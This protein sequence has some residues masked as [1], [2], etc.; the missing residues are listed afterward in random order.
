MKFKSGLNSALI[1]AALLLGPVSSALSA[2][3]FTPPT[4]PPEVLVPIFLTFGGAGTTQALAWSWGAARVENPDNP[5]NRFTV[6]F[7]DV[8]VTRWIDEQSPVFPEK[9]ALGEVV[10]V[11]TLATGDLTL[12]MKTVQ[13]TS[14][15]VG[16]S[17]TEDSQTENITLNFEEFSY[18]VGGKEFCWNIESGEGGCGPR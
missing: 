7:Q 1:S 11:A 3:P 17:G 15:S 14:Y 16:S 2:P 4:D 13:V 10:P 6:D 12:T 9:M 8:T 5:R 18:Q